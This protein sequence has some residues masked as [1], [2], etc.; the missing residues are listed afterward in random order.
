MV[1]FCT[2]IRAYVVVAVHKIRGEQK[3]R[4][5]GAVDCCFNG[6]SST[7]IVFALRSISSS[8][9]LSNLLIPAKHLIFTLTIFDTAKILSTYFETLAANFHLFI[10]SYT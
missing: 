5:S 6:L 10:S 9:Q 3:C 1:A 4:E 7:Q 2:K 8:S